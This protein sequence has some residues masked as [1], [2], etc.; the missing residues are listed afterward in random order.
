MTDKYDAL[1]ERLQEEYTF[2]ELTALLHI[3]IDTLRSWM[4]KAKVS[5]IRSG[6]RQVITKNTVIAL[7]RHCQ[8]PLL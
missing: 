7:L 1:V 5:S 3:S 8:F 4:H 2:E 6:R